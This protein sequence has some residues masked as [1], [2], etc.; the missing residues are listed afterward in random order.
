M[1]LMYTFLLEY[2][3]KDKC[4]KSNWKFYTSDSTGRVK[5]KYFGVVVCERVRIFVLFSSWQ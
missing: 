4:R 1:I 2:L 3:R 5:A